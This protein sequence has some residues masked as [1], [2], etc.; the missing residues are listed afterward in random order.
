[1]HEALAGAMVPN[2]MGRPAIE[3]QRVLAGRYRLEERLGG[4]GMG[5]I[6]RAE[7]MAL[8]SPVAVK[9]ID[10]DAVHDEQTVARFLREA[11]AAAALRSHHVVHIIDYGMDDNVPFI[12]M[13]LL[14]GE[15][16]A[17]RLKRVR[18]LTA[19]DTARFVSHV[20]R[21]IS[22]AHE[23]GIVHRDL[24]PENVFIVRNE[25]EEIA[26][27]LDFGVAK[28]EQHGVL[29]V[30][31]EKTRTGSILGTPYY[32]S[33]EQA[34]GNKAVDYRSD[35]WSLGVIAFECV[36]GKR[37]FYS[38]GLGDLVLQI[39]VRQLPV[40][41]EVA[42]VPLGFDAWFARAVEREPE[43]RFQSAREMTDAL[44]EA[45]CIETRE[46][47]NSSPEILVQSGSDIGASGVASAPT[48]T[49]DPKLLSDAMA[50]SGRFDSPTPAADSSP[51]SSPPKSAAD[52]IAATVAVSPA[53]STQGE[54]RERHSAS[55]P[56]SGLGSVVGVAAVALALGL[57]GG[58]WALQ[59]FGIKTRATPLP[60]TYDDVP[61]EP[62][63]ALP[64]KKQGARKDGS[65]SEGSAQTSPSGSAR[66]SASAT[67]SASASAHE[68]HDV[69][70][71]ASARPQ[72]TV[73]A[74]WVKPAWAI[75]DP[76]PKR[77]DDLPD[78]PPER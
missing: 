64:A 39:C 73:D 6:W 42:A 19:T 38:D 9:L 27:V 5:A 2:R 17:Q 31:G 65:G 44:R 63:A 40:P 7:H 20:G 53:P 22:R 51:L 24:K 21:A 55:P 58:V 32:M 61:S 45:L 23:A 4:G 37:P 8:Q 60:S 59:H 30:E 76:E 3:P 70:A 69:P 13:E 78:A 11:K 68:H 29:A 25:D 47:R 1:M 56:A 43:K 62:S 66:V 48:T 28:I 33:P 57:G 15:T 71:E 35:L 46:L 34:Q 10:R 72:S 54:S 50:A 41:S 36:T 75:P 16:L 74:G 12:V 52:P 14:E 77:I 18:R 26:K 67:P 49:R